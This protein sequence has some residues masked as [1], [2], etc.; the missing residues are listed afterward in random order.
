MYTFLMAQM[1][2]P[3]RN[4]WGQT[5]LKD[6]EE[7]QIDVTLDEIEKMS[8]FQFSS[9]VKKKEKIHTLD[10]LNSK[11][12]R[13]SK[14]KHIPHTVL[15]MEDYLRPHQATIRECKFLFAARC[16]MLDIRAN[17]SGQH[18]DTLCPLCSREEDTQ[19]H[20]MVCEKLCDSVTV[21]STLPE[22][23]FLFEKNLHDKINVSRL[24][25]SQLQKR[26]SLL[27]TK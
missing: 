4:D 20:L 23:K 10:Y 25:M 6:I 2:Q 8:P 26:S 17:Y 24:L 5:I 7:F 19:Q 14:V 18:E 3:T 22:Y 11:K 15:E 16:R 1:E 13:H 9:L 27:K 12:A 21:V